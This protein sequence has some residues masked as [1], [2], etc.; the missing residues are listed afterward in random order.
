MN[1]SVTAEAF[2]ENYVKVLTETFK[3]LTD[4]LAILTIGHDK[5][6]AIRTK[7]ELILA[8]ISAGPLESP[9]QEIQATLNTLKEQLVLVEN[10]KQL[11]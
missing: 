1:D 6:T 9:Y 4:S 7:I 3:G 5:L 11:N 8:V 2:I 10:L